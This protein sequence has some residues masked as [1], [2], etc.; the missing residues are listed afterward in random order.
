LRHWL[1][2]AK[3]E[4]SYPAPYVQFLPNFKHFLL[5]IDISVAFCGS[6]AVIGLMCFM[7]LISFS[8]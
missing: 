3:E 5:F 8:A 2:Q 7:R 1:P 6:G 4:P